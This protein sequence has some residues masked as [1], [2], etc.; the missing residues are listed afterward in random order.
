MCVAD[1]RAGG[2]RRPISAGSRATVA[3]HR[4]RHPD[5][6]SARRGVLAPG[7]GLCARWTWRK[8]HQ[9]GHRWSRSWRAGFGGVRLWGRRGTWAGGQG[10]HAGGSGP[11]PQESSARGEALGRAEQSDCTSPPT[12][13]SRA[14]ESCVWRQHTARAGPEKGAGRERVGGDGAGVA[15]AEGQGVSDLVVRTLNR[16]ALRV[17]GQVRDHRDIRDH[18]H[19]RH[20]RRGPIGQ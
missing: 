19:D 13:H 20:R 14:L 8:R 2:G 1:P 6:P 16:S 9:R 11:G 7:S 5:R 15:G 12:P 17:Q 10:F 4:Q 3:T 18:G